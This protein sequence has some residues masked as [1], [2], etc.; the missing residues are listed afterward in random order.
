MGESINY[1]P[2]SAAGL[3]P[4]KFCFSKVLFVVDDTGNSTSPFYV[5]V[6]TYIYTVIL[7]DRGRGSAQ[8]K[9]MN[10]TLKKAK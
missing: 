8:E 9:E 4:R 3:G 6:Y 1:I 5:C 7:S 2:T 10:G